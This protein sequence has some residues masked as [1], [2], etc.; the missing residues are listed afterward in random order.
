MPVDKNGG[1]YYRQIN[2]VG[3]GSNNKAMTQNPSLMNAA[4]EGS[5]KNVPVIN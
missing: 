1:V 4:K 2:Y 3:E 5:N